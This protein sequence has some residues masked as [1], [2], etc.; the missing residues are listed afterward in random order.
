M[1]RAYT[2]A[3]SL[4]TWLVPLLVMIYNEVKPYIVRWSCGVQDPFADDTIRYTNFCLKST[5]TKVKYIHEQGVT[6]SKDYDRL[7]EIQEKI[8]AE[9]EKSNE[10]R[11]ASPTYAAVNASTQ[12]DHAIHLNGQ[13]GVIAKLF[14]HRFGSAPANILH[15][16]RSAGDYSVN[17]AT[18]SPLAF[19]TPSTRS[20]PPLTCPSLTCPPQ[21]CCCSYSSPPNLVACP[22]QT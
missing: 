4:G 17:S 2:I 9:M 15:F 1:S 19:S 14:G 16:L 8:L 10:A 21:S 20:A 13:W 5:A 3:G 18:R 11:N 7:I 22:Y 12:I 6:A